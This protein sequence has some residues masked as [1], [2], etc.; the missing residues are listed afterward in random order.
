LFR[1]PAVGRSIG[2]VIAI[3][4]LASS[5][6][7]LARR[8]GPGPFAEVPIQIRSA[9]V[10]PREAPSP[11]PQADGR[12]ADGSIRLAAAPDPRLV[13]QSR[14]GLLPKIG[15][16]GARPSAVYARPAPLGP[17]PKI[18]VLITGLGISQSATIEA[19]AKLPPDITLAFAPYGSDLERSVEQARSGGHEVMLQVPMEPFDYPDNDPGPHTLM[20]RGPL[21]DKM[22]R[23]HWVMGRFSGYVG[24][25]N[26]MGARLLAD[27]EAMAPIL[28]EIAGRGLLFVED[29]TFGRSGGDLQPGIAARAQGTLDAVPQADAIDRE[30]ERL[31]T[32]ARERGS[33]FATASAGPTTLDRIVRWTHTLEQKGI[34]LVPV[35]S[36][37][38]EAKA[39]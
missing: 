11:A 9:P 34:R 2:A 3:A 17:S 6:F 27:R 26:A 29:G 19:I 24:L 31:E 32:A 21:Q 30:L 12:Q 39:P 37:A 20:R 15:S 38:S 33:A 18:A 22:E 10:P 13:E 36:I 35:S 16:D 1:S 28:S 25:V 5:A 8:S 14:F 23:L 7:F 4:A